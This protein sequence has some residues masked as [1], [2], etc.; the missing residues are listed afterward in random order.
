MNCPK[1][2]SANAEGATFCISCGTNLTPAPTTSP[3]GA[4]P[5]PPP[6]GG[7]FGTPPPPPGYQQPQGGFGQ[8]AYATPGGYPQPGYGQQVSNYMGM[9]IAAL[10]VGFLCSCLGVIPGIVSVVFA[11]QVNGKVSTGDIGGAMQASKNAKTWAT[12]AFIVT[13]VLFVLGIIFRLAV[14]STTSST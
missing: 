14:F 2:G 4:P 13:G 3:G 12:I 10:V 7:G 8:P 9:A 5:P 11:S 6:P 1:C